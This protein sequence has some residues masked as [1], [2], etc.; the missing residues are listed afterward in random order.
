MEIKIQFDVL[1]NALLFMFVE[2]IN[3]LDKRPYYIFIGYN[4]TIT[5][6]VKSEVLLQDPK[7]ANWMSAAGTG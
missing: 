7:T 4:N 2:L 3:V 6:E 1:N 5:N